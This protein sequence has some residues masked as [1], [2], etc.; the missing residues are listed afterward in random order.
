MR[1][2]ERSRV[3]TMILTQNRAAA[4]FGNAARIA[5]SGARVTKP[6]DDPVAYGSKVRRDY[7]I[8]ML[9]ER[10]KIASRAEGELTVV[11]NALSAASD[12]LIQAKET[13]IQGASTTTDP[14]ARKLLAED[15]R[16][17][18]DSLLSLA[19]TKYGEKYLFGG[20]RSD[21]LPFS[22]DGTFNGNDQVVR[23]PVL[24]GV[25]PPSNVS[26]AKAFT[27]AGGRDIFADLTALADALDSDNQT[28]VKDLI[29]P[30]STNHEQ[31]VRAQVEAGFNAE[32]F[33][34]AADV[35]VSTKAA[36]AERLSAE[37]EGDPAEQITELTLARNA[38]ER[39]VAVTKQLLSIGTGG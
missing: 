19:N 22:P 31:V 5:A 11:Q 18:R 21:T 24:E 25:S 4:R 27:V 1:V 29:T 37:I 23:V 39:S 33:R 26:G 14:K 28:A 30:L 17:M 10:S 15:V 12:M 36:V 34:T 2:T 7:A 6:S 16:T 13:A 38:Y 35:L 32:R 9:E 8:A 20:T 3:G